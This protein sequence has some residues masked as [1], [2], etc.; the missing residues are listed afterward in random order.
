MDDRGYALKHYS[1]LLLK[2]VPWGLYRSLWFCTCPM[3]LWSAMN[4]LYENSSK[5]Q[6]MCKMKSVPLLFAI[7]DLSICALFGIF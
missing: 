7:S 2:V 4:R 1:T 5:N 6:R 3:N